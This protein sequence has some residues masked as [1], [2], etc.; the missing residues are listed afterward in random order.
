MLYYIDYARR[1]KITIRSDPD[2]IN[3]KYDIYYH[4][5]DD[6]YCRHYNSQLVRFYPLNKWK[7]L[8]KRLSILLSHCWHF[9]SHQI[10]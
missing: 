5:M 4:I 9:I 1:I 8:W 3:D 7:R 6:I 10:M 2:W